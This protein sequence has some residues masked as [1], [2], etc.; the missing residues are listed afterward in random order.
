MNVVALYVE[1]RG[2]YQALGLDCWDAKRDAR[3]YAGASKVIAHPPCGPWGRLSQFC[4]KDDPALA[5]HAVEQVR[6][7]GGVLEHPAFSR[8]WEACGLPEPDTFF[9]DEFGGRAYAINQGDYGHRAPKATWLYAVGLPPC[10][11][12]APTG[13]D[14]GHRVN[15]MGA[16]ERR[17]TP[18]PLARELVNWVRGAYAR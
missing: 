7:W 1:T 10:P 12:K 13:F 18:E 5:L 4:T 6:R 16:P 15:N 3:N 17:R 9:P 14:P 11:L 2:H 8:L